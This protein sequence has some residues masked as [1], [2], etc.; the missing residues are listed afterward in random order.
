MVAEEARRSGGHTERKR[1]EVD[2]IRHGGGIDRRQDRAQLRRSKGIARRATGAEGG[3]SGVGTELKV[4]ITRLRRTERI[5]A[6]RSRWSRGKLE[7]SPKWRRAFWGN[8]G[9]EKIR[10][11]SVRSGARLLLVDG[12][13]AEPGGH[14]TK[15][16]REASARG[17]LSYAP[18]SP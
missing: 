14:E 3:R 17:H 10:S 7:G 2:G 12:A 6:I 5:D 11:G 8:D 1:D 4:T 16:R 13:D 18:K 9:A 15:R